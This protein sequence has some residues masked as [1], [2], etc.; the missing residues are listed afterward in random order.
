M[1][2]QG[3]ASGDR[4][5]L[6]L[7]VLPILPAGEP[8][9]EFQSRDA[10][11][12]VRLGARVGGIGL[13]VGY[14]SSDGSDLRM[15]T[16]DIHTL[17]LPVLRG[18]NTLGGRGTA[19]QEQVLLHGFSQ[20]LLRLSNPLVVTCGGRAMD[21]PFLR[22]RSLATGV[23]LSGLHFSLGSRLK[24]FERYD[25]G[26]HLDLCDLLA[27]YGATLPL[28]L[29]EICSLTQVDICKDTGSCEIPDRAY[30]ETRAVVALFL[31]FLHVIGRL[32]MS[33]YKRALAEIGEI[34][35]RHDVAARL[36]SRR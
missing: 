14:L 22:Y 21:L 5:F 17:C 34:C 11:K 20:Q 35:V 32:A 10:G 7:R 18:K 13:A 36:E 26:W 6:A 31:R 3:N 8:S 1:W 12:L 29:R 23:A 4:D 15:R 33:E 30:G 27:G 25:H 16:T 28:S 9:D 19:D 2:Q 24:Y